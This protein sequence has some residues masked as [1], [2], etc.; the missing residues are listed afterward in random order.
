MDLKIIKSFH[1]L[2]LVDHRVLHFGGSS[3]IEAQFSST[4][5]NFLSSFYGFLRWLLVDLSLQ[6]FVVDFSEMCLNIL[7]NLVKVEITFFLGFTIHFLDYS[8]S[9]VRIS[10]QCSAS[11]WSSFG[12]PVDLSELLKCPKII[13]LENKELPTHDLD[14]VAL[15][16]LISW[17]EEED[18]PLPLLRGETHVS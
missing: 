3:V 18:E 12:L 11:I 14:L 10:A 2:N 16:L 1:V 8:L 15:S 5:G 6:N 9:S 13:L 7:L 17:A 4:L